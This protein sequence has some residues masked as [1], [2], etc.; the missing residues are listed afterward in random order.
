MFAL[1]AMNLLSKLLGGFSLAALLALAVLG[2]RLHAVTGER[3]ALASWQGD[4]TQAARDAAHHPK[5]GR[6]HVAQQIRNLGGALDQVRTAMATARANALDAKL[7]R[8]QEDEH[9]RKEADDALA[10]QLAD[11]RRRADDHARTHG[12]RRGAGG[13]GNDPGGDRAADLPAPAFAAAFDH[14]PG[15]PAELVAITPADLNTCT[16]NSLRLRN[17][18]GWASTI[19]EPP[20]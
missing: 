11:G 1:P 10:V 2:W 18:H 17:A 3:D 4:V 7:K 5:L 13:P 12:V 15:D 20:Q 8:E 19:Q 6:D 9:R 16:D 14:G